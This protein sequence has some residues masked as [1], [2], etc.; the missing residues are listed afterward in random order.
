MAGKKHSRLTISS[1][2]ENVAVAVGKDDVV[3]KAEGDT[4]DVAGNAKTNIFMRVF[5]RVNGIP[6]A[7]DV[8]NDAA[9]MGGVTGNKKKFDTDPAKV[10]KFKA[11]VVGPHSIRMLAWDNQSKITS[12]DEVR[13]KVSR[14]RVV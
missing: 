11:R 3:A 12:A 8:Y 10:T 6:F 13:Q 14:F 7:I 1:P 2:D 5:Y 4:E 9:V